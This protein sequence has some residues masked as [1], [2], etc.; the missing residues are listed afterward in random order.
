[1]NMVN[2]CKALSETMKTYGIKGT[3]V[4]EKAGLTNQTISNF[5]VGKTQIKSES[6]EKIIS[7]L[8]PDARDYFFQQLHPVNRDLKSL[9]FRAT[10]DEK[11]EVLRIVA[12]SLSSGIADNNELPVAV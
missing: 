6:L 1:M 8:P 4:A 7:A 9:I 3:W 2:F 12:A 5:L 11:A 10:N